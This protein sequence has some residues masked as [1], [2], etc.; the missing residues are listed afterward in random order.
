MFIGFQT[1]TD[2]K[3]K[4]ASQRAI[5]MIHCPSWGHEEELKQATI[6][7]MSMFTAL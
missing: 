5:W 1:N 4:E 2:G 3:H 6:T 7:E